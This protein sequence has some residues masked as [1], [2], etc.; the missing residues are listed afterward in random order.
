VAGAERDEREA[1]YRRY[2]GCCN[3]HDLGRIGEFVAPDVQVDGEPRG[4]DGYVAALR[5]WIE[6]FPDVRW[7][8]RRLLVDGDWIAGH[9]FLSG[10]HGGAFHGVPATGRTVTT[11]EFAVYRIADGVIAEVAGAVD[12]VRLLEQLR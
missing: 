3:A 9:F 7:E 4:L 1:F 2:N 12:E 8:I 5:G 6:A 11:R 10:T